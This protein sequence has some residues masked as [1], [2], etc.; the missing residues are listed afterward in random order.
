VA[1]VTRRAPRRLHRPTVV[2]RALALVAVGVWVV[3]PSTA[4]AA[5]A[6]SQ[7]ASVAVKAALPSD[8]TLITDSAVRALD[9]ASSK[10]QVDYVA[11]GTVD[12]RR[13]FIDGTADYAI[14]GVP[15]SASELADLNKT[16]RGLI[17]APIQAVGM[18][19]FGFVP[20]L[21]IFPIR[22]ADP[23]NTDC[24]PADRTPYTGRFRF[25]SGTMADLY[26]ERSNIWTRP[27]VSANLD[28]D[29]AT[30]FAVPP[31]RGARPLVRS[32][33]DAFNFYLD[34]YLALVEPEL[35]RAAIN[36]P[37][38]NAPAPPPSEVWPIYTAPSRQGMD[39]VVSQIREGLDPGS[40]G[41]SEGGSMTAT[42]PSYVAESITVNNAKPVGQRVAL[43][44][45]AY[46]RN[47]ANEWVLPTPEAIT[48]AVAAGNG[49]PLT[50]AI[51]TPV[52]GAYPVTWVNKLYAPASGL[53]ADQANGVATMI[54]WQVGIGR[55][56]AA[57]F[58][59][60]QITPAMVSTA[61]DAANQVVE[62]NCAAAK[63]KVYT[64]TDGGPFAPPG[65]LGV[66]GSMKLC[67]GTSTTSSE[68][69]AG[70]TT[71]AADGAAADATFDA[72]TATDSGGLSDLTASASG[73]TTATDASVSDSS[74]GGSASGAAGSGGAGAG[75]TDGTQVVA[76]QR[77]MPFPIPGLSLSPLDRMV[78]LCIGAGIFVVLRS[79]YLRRRASA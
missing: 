58:G 8:S 74:T 44:P 3:L 36:G 76:A 50:G 18:E 29:Q 13:S 21:S 32:D 23:D 79:L 68:P 42:T 6:P 10:T 55:T 51:G 12:A 54:R 15:F 46:I 73:D 7:P 1:E 41:I 26:Y 59:D 53:T 9:G 35:R 27:D 17:E 71:A 11:A 40:S 37:V 47:A 34:A 78:T 64:T 38:S 24:T 70:D 66:T 45:A 31:I 33:A 75:T 19:F 77:K 49:T 48:T 67:E 39:N 4:R 22:C 2:F 20:S 14:S 63:G 28:I 56:R 60:G 62:S 61:L 43:F 30:Q 65:G 69:A 72:G 57:E 16:G 5:D 25:T 52:P